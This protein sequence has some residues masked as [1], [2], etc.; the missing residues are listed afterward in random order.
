[1]YRNYK[2]LNNGVSTVFDNSAKSSFSTLLGNFAEWQKKA[3]MA[4]LF[5]INIIC[6]YQTFAKQIEKNDFHSNSIDL[7]IFN[8]NTVAFDTELILPIVN[9]NALKNTSNNKF[10]NL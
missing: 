3:F 10:N 5:L 2:S 7:Q 4:M 6:S 8:S 1:M 9:L